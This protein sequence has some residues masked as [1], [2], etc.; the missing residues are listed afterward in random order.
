MADVYDRLRGRARAEKVKVPMEVGHYIMWAN[1]PEW[2]EGK[3][4][5]LIM[6]WPYRN[7]EIQVLPL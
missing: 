5:S 2:E 1:N 7:T 6:R 4:G 3:T